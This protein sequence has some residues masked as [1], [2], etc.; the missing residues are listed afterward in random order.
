M[1][2]HPI[3][4]HIEDFKAT[5]PRLS[6]Q[7]GDSKADK[8]YRCLSLAIGDKTDTWWPD[9]DAKWLPGLPR[10]ENLNSFKTFFSRFGFEEC[11][12]G[13]FEKGYCKVAFYVA[14]NDLVEHVAIQHADRNGKW[15]SK[16]GMNVNV[17]HDL[18]EVGGGAYGEAVSFMR[19]DKP[20]PLAK[21]IRLGKTASGRA[22]LRHR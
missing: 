5:V 6:A 4:G 14:S 12:T 18:N 8:N 13:D 2:K 3:A 22:P 21:V 19:S 11:K 17:Y 7:R 16:I 10:D 1:S 20:Q 9:P 15:H